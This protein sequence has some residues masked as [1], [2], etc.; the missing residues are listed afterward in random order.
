MNTLSRQ[1]PLASIEMRMPCSISKPV[2][3]RLVN[4]LPCAVL[5]I[6]GLPYFVIAFQK[7]I[8]QCQLADLGVQHLQ[9]DRGLIRSQLAAEHIG[10][11]G[12]QLV[13]PVGDLVGVY[14][15]LL[16]QLGQR[17]VA[18]NGGQRYLGLECR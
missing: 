8:L 18:P 7:I 10:R 4:W 12:Q 11:L 1:Q 3:A 9:I 16:C 14:V 15:M 2:N 13:L 6:S 5:N 17:L